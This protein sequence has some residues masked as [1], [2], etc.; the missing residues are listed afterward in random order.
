MLIL[1]FHHIGLMIPVLEIF[2]GHP[3]IYK[4]INGLMH[5]K[6]LINLCVSCKDGGIKQV[7]HTRKFSSSP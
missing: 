4:Y 6:Q 2:T 1:G 3:V 5:K 7:I